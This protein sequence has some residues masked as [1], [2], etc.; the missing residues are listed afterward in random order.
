[1]STK[2]TFEKA[3]QRLKL[4]KQAAVIVFMLLLTSFV[5]A[6]IIRQNVAP[7][8][9]H[10]TGWYS[11]LTF[12]CLALLSLVLLMM[13]DVTDK[14][15]Y[16]PIKLLPIL[17]VIQVIYFIVA[18]KFMFPRAYSVYKLAL[19]GEFLW[20]LV[21]WRANLLFYLVKKNGWLFSLSAP[22]NHDHD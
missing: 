3:R 4:L 9:A 17:S 6:A 5:I 18:W 10:V 1:M 15:F 16:L 12:N 11:I 8:G 20:L 21:L 22:S 2:L 19:P 7:T 13:S 14:G